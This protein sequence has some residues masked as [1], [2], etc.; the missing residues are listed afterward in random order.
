MRT[1]R[2][3]TATLAGLGLVLSL[4][5]CSDGDT[6]EASAAYCA[7]SAVVQGEVADLKTLV[8]GGQATID[9]VQTQVQAIGAARVQALGDAADL[10]ES[11]RNDIK[12]ADDAFDKAVAAIPGDATLSEAADS[13]QAAIDAWDAAMASIRTEAGC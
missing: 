13:Y 6:A 3:I 10:A 8:S 5:A 7:S 2:T 9:E 12:A 1:T 11:V 4:S